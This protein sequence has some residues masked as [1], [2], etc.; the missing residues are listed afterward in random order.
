M[1][2]VPVEI[3]APKGNEDWTV[4]RKKL[5]RSL[6]GRCDYDEKEIQIQHGVH[7]A[8]MLSTLIHEATHAAAPDLDEH[9]VERIEVSI[10]NTIWPFLKL[11]LDAEDELT[12][13]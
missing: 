4:V 8:T 6:Y 1:K 7:G 13:D 2:P 9:A 10:L 5:P 12:D 3:T 11:A